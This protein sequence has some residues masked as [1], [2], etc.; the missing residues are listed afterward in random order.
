LCDFG[1]ATV[2]KKNILRKVGTEGYMAPELFENE[3]F[4]NFSEI[5]KTDIFALG[6]ILFLLLFSFP[7]F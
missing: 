1:F 5:V 2:E 4:L 7:L 3:N 6:V